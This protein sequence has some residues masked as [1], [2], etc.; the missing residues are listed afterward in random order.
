MGHSENFGDIVEVPNDEARR[1]IEA[2][3]AELYREKQIETTALNGGRERAVS[4]R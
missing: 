1:M 3:Q 2:G 4:R